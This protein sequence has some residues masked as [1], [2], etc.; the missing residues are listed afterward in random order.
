MLSMRSDAH[1]VANA[2]GEE[3]TRHNS[4]EQPKIR[5][6]DL[7]MK[8]M[9][10]QPLAS[11]ENA[12]GL[13][14][15][16]HRRKQMLKRNVIRDGHNRVIGSV[17]SGFAGGSSLVRDAEGRLLGKTSELFHNTRDSQGKLVSTNTP[18]AGLLFGD[19]E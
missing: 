8:P 16:R 18:D 2:E 12:R 17:T 11:D 6:S 7:L 4:W 14:I 3:E 10:L 5:L 13:C 1:Q 9:A 19:D 15:L